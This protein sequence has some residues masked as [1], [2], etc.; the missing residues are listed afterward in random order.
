MDSSPGSV[1]APQTTRM[2]V[3]PR[4]WADYAL[5][6]TRC[7]RL[8]DGGR[9]AIVVEEWGPNEFRIHFIGP[10]AQEE[11]LTAE[12]DALSQRMKRPHYLQGQVLKPGGTILEGFEP[13]TWDDVALEPA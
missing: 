4:D 11:V 10:R 13:A 3:A 5:E 1:W 6:T 8:P 2:L 12:F 9:R 7:Y